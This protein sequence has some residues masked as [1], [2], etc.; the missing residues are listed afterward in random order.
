MTSGEDSW[1][2]TA[3]IGNRGQDGQNMTV[4]IGLLGSDKRDGTTVAVQSGLEI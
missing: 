2:S 1:D 4:D 3:R